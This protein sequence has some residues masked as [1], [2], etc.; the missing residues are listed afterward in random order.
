MARRLVP[1]RRPSPQAPDPLDALDLGRLQRLSALAADRLAGRP[2]HLGGSLLGQ[3]AAGGQDFLDH[4]AFVAGDDPR[5]IDWRASA[6]RQEPV[7]RRYRDQ[8]ASDW[9]IALDRSASMGVDGTWPL[10]VQLA[11]A[12]AFVLTAHGHRLLLALFSD[13]LDGTAGP[14][15]CPQTLSA[16]YALLRASSPKPPSNH[17][18][19]RASTD[20]DT[21]LRAGT[22]GI[23]A[24]S[25]PE[26][27]LSLTRGRRMLL[28]SD[29]L[30]ADGMSDALAVLSAAAAG[31]ELIR[32]AAPLPA[33]AG[34]RLLVDAE[35]GERRRLLCSSDV[36]QTARQNSMRLFDSLSERCRRLGIPLTVADV[37][38]PW[39]HALLSHL[40]E[41]CGNRQPQPL[42][43]AHADAHAET[44]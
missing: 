8:H 13:R 20:N 34:D 28:I 42:G 23:P 4:R 7:V 41:R 24:G 3:Q 39:E 30:R 11:A 6:R 44:P 32:I 19:V 18:P 26:S 10:A 37:G 2:L 21:P 29:C 16:V 25:R 1:L 17:R 35:T 43:N 12:A 22:D 36:V 40:L 27:C 31:V 15:R 14:G 33:L 38:Q 9:L 5:R